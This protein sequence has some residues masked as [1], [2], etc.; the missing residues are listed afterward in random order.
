[1]REGAKK[2]GGDFNH[3]THFPEFHHKR[4]NCHR[5]DLQS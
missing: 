2:R 4:V 5:R 3:K 1:M